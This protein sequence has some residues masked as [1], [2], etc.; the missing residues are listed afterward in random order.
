ME[1]RHSI[2]DEAAA[3]EDEKRIKKAKTLFDA[4]KTEI[5]KLKKVI[6]DVKAA[7]RTDEQKA[8]L[9]KYEDRLKVVSGRLGTIDDEIAAE[10]KKQTDATKAR[11]EKET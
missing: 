2:E 1:K 11:K 9:K 3:K 6:D 4:E 8:D 10:A 5:D 7:D